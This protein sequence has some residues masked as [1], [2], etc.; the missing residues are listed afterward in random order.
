MTTLKTKNASGKYDLQDIKRRITI[1]AVWSRLGLKGK[2]GTSCTS[3]FRAESKPSFS[4]Y[5]N[6]RKWKDHAT[7]EQGDI[8]DFY[9]KATGCD[10]TTAINDLAGF[11]GASRTASPL[12]L[13]DP[14]PTPPPK[15][16][17]MAKHEKETLYTAVLDLQFSVELQAFTIHACNPTN[18][19]IWKFETISKLAGEGSLGWMKTGNSARPIFSYGWGWKWRR[20]PE[21]IKDGRPKSQ[22]AKGHKPNTHPVSLWRSFRLRPGRQLVILTEGETDAISLV[23]SGVEQTITGFDNVAVCALPSAGHRLKKTE[24]EKLKD[25][26][27]ILCADDDDAGQL[28]SYKNAS[29]L[30]T[31]GITA[32]ILKPSELIEIT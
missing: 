23:D 28:S 25:S 27:V 26:I 15:P 18:S 8:F 30:R 12:S 21:E 16:S 32:S 5:A 4:V 7:G 13:P 22:W 17:E 24:I 29:L 2:P 10:Q 19:L 3:P 11:S 1:A 20:L 9:Q 31:A 6:G 14:E